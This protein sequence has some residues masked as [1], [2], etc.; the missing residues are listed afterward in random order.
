[1]QLANRKCH[2]IVLFRQLG[3][4]FKYKFRI[5]KPTEF[6]VVYPVAFSIRRL[7]LQSTALGRAGVSKFV[8]LDRPLIHLVAR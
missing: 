3:I 6:L 5:G 8:W 7:Y 2:V 1:M 4:W